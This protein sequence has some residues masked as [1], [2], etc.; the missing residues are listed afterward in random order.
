[1]TQPLD[2]QIPHRDPWQAVVIVAFCSLLLALTCCGGGAVLAS[3]WNR[4]SSKFLSGLTIFLLSAGNI[5]VLLFLLMILAAIG[6][7]IFVA[8]RGRNR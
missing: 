6:R 2:P 5:F 8:I 3:Y 1:M 7:R 4:S